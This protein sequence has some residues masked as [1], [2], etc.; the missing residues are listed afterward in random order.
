MRW[1][2]NRGRERQ[3]GE[4]LESMAPLFGGFTGKTVLEVGA[5]LSGNLLRVVEQRFSPREIVG[6]NLTATNQNI[7]SRARLE[8][9]DIRS[10]SY[11]DQT[12]DLIISVS[13]FEHITGLER[14]LMEMHRILRPG[15]YVFSHFGPI[16]S[17][18]YGHH[19]STRYGMR[20]YTYWNVMLPP[21][22]HLLMSAREIERLLVGRGYAPDL[23]R[24]MSEYVTSSKDQ[25]QLFFEDYEQLFKR[26]PFDIVL[27]KGYDVP[28]IAQRYNAEITPALLDQLK[29]R[30]PGKTHFFYDGIATL[31]RKR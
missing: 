25:N 8:Q 2:R 3:Y 31:L 27:F 9:G 24:A 13:A 12:F 23:A 16:W 6:I 10:T 29:A 21:Y 1:I 26:S 30:F 5:D 4:W 14:A 28:E 7:S 11:A 15:G 22:C 17:T 18:S 19:L 20:N